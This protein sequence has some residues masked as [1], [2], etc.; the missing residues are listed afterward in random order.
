MYCCI[1]CFFTAAP[2]ERHSVTLHKNTST[3]LKNIRVKLHVSCLAICTV[4]YAMQLYHQQLML[5]KIMSFRLNLPAPWTINTMW[6]PSPHPVDHHI[7]HPI[8]GYIWPTG[9]TSLYQGNHCGHTV[10]FI[11]AITWLYW[12]QH[13]EFIKQASK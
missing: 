3:F 13:S 6:T 1:F 11:C 8:D 12:E 10:W 4:S 5:L 2:T 7:D 9:P